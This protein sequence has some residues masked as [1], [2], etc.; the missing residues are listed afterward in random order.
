[1]WRF[2]ELGNVGYQKNSQYLVL[3]PF[4]SHS[5]SQ[6][7]HVELIVECCSLT[8]FVDVQSCWLLAM[9][10]TRCC[11]HRSRASQTCSRGDMSGETAARARTTI[12]YRISSL[13][14]FTFKMPSRCACV[15][16]LQHMLVHNGPLNPQCWHQ[17]TTHPYGST[18]AY[19]HLPCT[20]KTRIHPWREHLSK[21]PDT[22]ECRRLPTHGCL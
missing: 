21:L 13:H 3:P 9:T 5:A 4:A 22:I 8:I 7:L 16:C 11:K 17:Q 15:C 20:E 12:G 10:E 2:N 18:H 19:Y 1:M 6:L 14:L